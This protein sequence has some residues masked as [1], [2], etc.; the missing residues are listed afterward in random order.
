MNNVTRQCH[1]ISFVDRGIG[2]AA[3]LLIR[4]PSIQVQSQQIEILFRIF[5]PAYSSWAAM[6]AVRRAAMWVRRSA[7]V[8][9]VKFATVVWGT[10]GAGS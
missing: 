7:V 10:R 2:A 9:A 8:T 3:P 4:Y 6:A 1:I 5:I